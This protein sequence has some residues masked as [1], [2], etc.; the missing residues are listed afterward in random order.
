MSRRNRS[1]N[2][3]ITKVRKISLQNDYAFGIISPVTSTTLPIPVP[4]R[5]GIS[6]ESKIP[7]IVPG[8]S[9]IEKRL[10]RNYDPND[11]NMP[12]LGVDPLCI[13]LGNSSDKFRRWSV[14]NFQQAYQITTPTG[15]EAS[16]QFAS[17]EDITDG[18]D[19]TNGS[20]VNLVEGITGFITKT[21]GKIRKLST[22]K[23]PFSDTN[24]YSPN[25]DLKE[26]LKKC[27][28]Y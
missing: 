8:P 22:E 17:D 27:Y 6:D 16:S 19:F 12:E 9:Q 4:L 14:S 18:M 1:L 21:S 11:P 3:D 5:R 13:S 20:Y 15:T 2:V 10:S 26:Q 23:K 24:I 28:V 25:Q 7:C